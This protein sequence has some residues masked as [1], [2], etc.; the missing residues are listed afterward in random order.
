MGDGPGTIP[1]RLEGCA[2]VI[3]DTDG[4][5]TDTA[6]VHAAAWQTLF[7]DYLRRR[8]DRDGDRFVPFDTG[9][10]YRCV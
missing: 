2:A 9:A 6:V 8:A 4:V 7:D 10:E 3:C 5:I 1:L